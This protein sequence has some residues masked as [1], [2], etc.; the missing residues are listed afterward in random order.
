MM[1]TF[2]PVERYLI[3]IILSRMLPGLQLANQY[4][5]SGRSFNCSK[6]KNSTSRCSLAHRKWALGLNVSPNMIVGE[7]D[8]ICLANH[9]D[10][11]LAYS[12]FIGF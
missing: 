2:N 8:N 7:I 6:H 3:R 9:N 1:V 12:R 10:F 4:S 5:G 11:A